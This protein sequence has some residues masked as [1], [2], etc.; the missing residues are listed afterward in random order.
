MQFHI[1]LGDDGS[2]LTKG[3]GTVS[4][5]R[6]SGNPLQLKDVLHVPGLK[7]NLVSVS[8][9]EDKGYDVIF[10]RGKA[11]FKHLES[12][13]MKQIGVRMKNIYKLQV[14]TNATLSHKAGSEHDIDVGELWHKCMGRLHHEAL[15]ILQQIAIGIPQC[16]ID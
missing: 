5:D 12:G 13:A 2:Y 9:L 6:E 8:T 10:S 16:S 3:V 7:K 4:F 11:Y 1:E 14:E 15:K